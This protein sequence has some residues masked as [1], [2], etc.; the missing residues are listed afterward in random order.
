MAQFMIVFL[1]VWGAVT[2]IVPTA[3]AIDIG[4]KINGYPAAQAMPVVNGPQSLVL[5]GK[6][7]VFIFWSFKC[8]V[9]LSYNERMNG[10]QNKYG[11]KGVV[12]LGVASAANETQE[13]IQA[14][15]ANLN[16]KVPVMLDSEGSFAEMLG[17][18]HTPSGFVFDENRTL[19]YKGALDNNKKVDENGR[20]AYVEEAVDAILA[21]RPVAVSETRL[22]GCSIRRRGVK[23]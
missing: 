4:S 5:T 14:N 21:G 17:A 20:V 1:A 15:I 19:R 18:S 7:V 22:F 6:L 12:V 10:I 16:L 9:A 3:M 2:S 8:P 11:H 13:E 23:E